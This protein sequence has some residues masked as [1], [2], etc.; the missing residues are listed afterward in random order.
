MAGQ[1][2]T[3][4]QTQTDTDNAGKAEKPAEQ[5]WAQKASQVAKMHGA[6]HINNPQSITAQYN[7]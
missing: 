2:H 3:Q 7:N 4:Q 5:A 6:A 1:G